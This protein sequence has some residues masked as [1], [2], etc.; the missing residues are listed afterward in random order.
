MTSVRWTCT[1]KGKIALLILCDNT[2][3]DRGDSE[4]MLTILLDSKPIARL[5][6]SSYNSQGYSAKSMLIE[7]RE[8]KE[9]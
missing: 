9:K 6:S 3:G 4:R 1:N 5:E 7:M 8:E 2:D